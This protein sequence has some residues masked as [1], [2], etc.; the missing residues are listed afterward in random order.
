MATPTVQQ[1][2]KTPTYA[3]LQAK[4][5]A[6]E[7][8][9]QAAKQ[10]KRQGITAIKASEKGAVSVYGLGRFPQTLYASQWESLAVEAFGF[11]DVDAFHAGCKLGQF[12]LDHPD[13]S[14]KE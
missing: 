3:E 7:A 1:T 8:Q 11:A 4:I 12:I 6:M 5:A 10:A 13:L 9:L 14:R 2:A